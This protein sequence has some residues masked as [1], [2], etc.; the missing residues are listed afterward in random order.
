LQSGDTGWVV[1]GNIFNYSGGVAY[2][3]SAPLSAYDLWF[4]EGVVAVQSFVV[5]TLGCADRGI[6]KSNRVRHSGRLQNEGKSINGG[7]GA[8]G[9]VH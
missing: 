1:E 5:S 9:G 7:I 6:L 2:Y 8:K 4:Q 3:K